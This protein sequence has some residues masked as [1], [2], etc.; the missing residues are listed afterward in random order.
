M[1]LLRFLLSLSTRFP[2]ICLLFVLILFSA[3]ARPVTPVVAPQQL[4]RRIKPS[5]SRNLILKVA[6]VAELVGRLSPGMM[7]TAK[8]LPKTEKQINNFSLALCPAP[9]ECLTVVKEPSSS[10]LRV[11]GI[12]PPKDHQ[13]NKFS[14][15]NMISLGANASFFPSSDKDQ[16]ITVRKQLEIRHQEKAEITAQLKDIPALQKA[17]KQGNGEDII[18]ENDRVWAESVLK[19]LVLKGKIAAE[20]EQGMWTLWDHAIATYKDHME[21]RKGLATY[22]EECEED[23]HK[24]AKLLWSFLQK[25]GQCE[26]DNNTGPHV[27]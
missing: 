4:Q 16:G 5:G 14:A 7:A 11:V 20:K 2:S 19:F 9:E 21:L 27:N 12:A 22:E 6:R 15:V 26:L 23:A 18:I 8:W 3:T 10:S 1:V 17:V 25:S 24:D 13:T